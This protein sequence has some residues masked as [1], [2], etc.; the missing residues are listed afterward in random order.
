MVAALSGSAKFFSKDV[1]DLQAQNKVVTEQKLVYLTIFESLKDPVIFADSNGKIR[2]M[3]RSAC[4]S[5]THYGI[6]GAIYYGR[7]EIDDA[8]QIF[9]PFLE[10]DANEADFPDCH[11]T[12][13][14]GPRRFHI[15][16]RRMIDSSERMAGIV[17]I[18]TDIT[19]Y[20]Q[21]LQDAAQADRAKSAFLATMSHELRTPAAGILGAAELL[22]HTGLSSSQRRYLDLIN[23]SASTLLSVLNEVLDYS[24][25]EETGV[26]VS[27]TDF[28]LGEVI[29][30]VA[31]IM[32]YQALRKSVAFTVATAANVPRR[33]RGDA[34]K[35]RHVL[36]NLVGN[37]VKF[38]YSGS[39][40]LSVKRIRSTTNGEILLK[41]SISDTGIGFSPDMAD[42]LFQPFT[43]ADDTI[44]RK[45]GGTGLGLT[46]CKRIVDA[47]GGEIDAKSEQGGST[48]WFT[49][50]FGR[51]EAPKRL[52]RAK[53][54]HEVPSLS[55]LMVEDN[56][57]NQ[58]V[59][60]GLLEHF[61]HTVGL[62]GD[63]KEALAMLADGHYDAIL[64]DVHL[65]GMDGY[66]IARQVRAMADPVKARTKIVALTADGNAKAKIECAAAGMDGFLM[67][68]LRPEELNRVLS[69]FHESFD[70]KRSAPS[71]SRLVDES[72]LSG[73]IKNLGKE[74]VDQIVT[75]F[76]TS[77]STFEKDVVP[78]VR[79]H[80]PG[81]IVFAVHR[82][83]GAAGNVGFVSLMDLA[84]AL[85]NDAP[86]LSPTLLKK[87]VRE[88]MNCLQASLE[89]FDGYV[90]QWLSTE[91]TK[92]NGHA[93][94]SAKA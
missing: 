85:E 16:A 70:D 9:K 80:E 77:V 81:Q 82:L 18:C 21:A 65:P 79:R 88:F 84:N 30:G 54:P 89:E 22:G 78:A 93:P 1:I 73:H 52:R 31:K 38:T 91:D 20:R 58:I 34:D 48:F 72:V 83:K 66:S 25:F 51:A 5:F 41:F 74:V 50:P 75:A 8:E 63:G 19:D 44:S 57:V 92:E 12:T 28:D 69:E 2:N 11:L 26:I 13:R 39:I 6:P 64:L 3:N 43:Q 71:T 49:V 37:A 7:T 42:R 17:L 23:A 55:I 45:F 67:K 4:L 35:L 87:R 33:L 27:N 32:R 76:R 14:S 53:T 46:I 56:E 36:M 68:P 60:V 29:D 86:L 61:G 94:L 40:E 59:G 24:K 90:E 10:F 47:W 62:A 15:K